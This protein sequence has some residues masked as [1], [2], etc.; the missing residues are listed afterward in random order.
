MAPAVDGTAAAGEAAT[1]VWSPPATLSSCATRETPQVL[2][3]SA[4]P[5]HATGPGAVVW[6]AARGCHSGE[7]LRLASIGADD[8]PGAESLP[9]TPTGKTIALPGQ[10]AASAAP[11]GELLLASAGSTGANVGELA[12]GRADGRFRSLAAVAQPLA[13]A[14]GYLGDVAVA[15]LATGHLG[16]RVERYF[17]HQLETRPVPRAPAT[18]TSRDLSLALDFRTDALAAWTEGASLMASWLPASGRAPALQRL[19]AVAGTVHIATLLSDDNRAIVAFSEDHQGSTRVRLA[20]SGS[21]VRF[22]TVK[23]LEQFRDPPVSP[24][25]SVPLRLVRLSSESV[26][27]AWAGVTA[28]RW[29]IRTAAIDLHGVGIPNTIA[30]ASGDALLAELAPGP[31]GDALLLWTEPQDDHAFSLY[32]ARGFDTYPNKTSFA[33]PEQVS[34][35]GAENLATLALDPTSDRA[36]AVWRGPQGRLQYSIRSGPAQP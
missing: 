21:G 32:A 24:T 4:S 20:R 3:P 7:G 35:P 22:A 31:S 25:P 29:V 10:L 26:M 15:S 14:R 33:A 11:H 18:G 2:F 28:G 6:R 17:A 16:L 5:S 8:V 36:V 34:P 19:A 9:Q 13:L 30:A 27:V 23:L 12:V 1:G